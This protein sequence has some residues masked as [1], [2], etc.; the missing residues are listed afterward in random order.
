MPGATA[1]TKGMAL[2]SGTPVIR[3]PMSWRSAA[4]QRAEVVG[5]GPDV[6]LDAH[7][8]IAGDLH[9][10]AVLDLPARLDGTPH[11]PALVVARGP[12]CRR[13]APPQ[14]TSRPARSP[15]RSA[16]PA[17]RDLR[18][19]VQCRGCTGSRKRRGRQHPVR[20]RR[21][22]RRTPPWRA[23]RRRR[24]RDRGSD[25]PSRG[26]PCSRV[27]GVEADVDGLGHADVTDTEARP[28]SDT[29]D[30][31]DEA[32]VHPAPEQRGPSGGRGLL[33]R[34]HLSGVEGRRAQEAPS[35]SPR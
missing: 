1:H 13:A 8:R 15:P 4:R 14:R 28:G 25:G 3:M 23:P 24:G 29:R 17:G 32:G 16:D 2:T 20:G 18:W 21:G 27:A 22:R 10:P 11:H 35:W 33:D 12:A 6:D 26:H 7:V 5:V 30:Q 9:D 19:R 34:R 31:V